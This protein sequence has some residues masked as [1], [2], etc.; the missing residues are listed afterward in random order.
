M[1]AKRWF[2]LIA[3][4]AL[5]GSGS[6]VAGG[7][8]VTAA[9]AVAVG[10]EAATA[11]SSVV[12]TQGL[13]VPRRQRR[14]VGTTGPLWTGRG[15]VLS[16][17]PKTESFVLRHQSGTLTVLID[18]QTSFAAGNYRVSFANLRPGAGAVVTVFQY[19]GVYV[20]SEVHLQ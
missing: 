4:I 1:E 11:A 13:Y 14:F 10:S 16:V 3:G 8:A 20:A 5:S 7:H 19:N 9:A 18:N 2:G 15:I 12:P 6:V 17:D